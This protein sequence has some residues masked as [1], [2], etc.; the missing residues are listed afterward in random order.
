[1][2]NSMK[3]PKRKKKDKL[4]YNIIISLRET[5]GKDQGLFIEGMSVLTCELQSTQMSTDRQ[6]DKEDSPYTPW[7][8]AQSRTVHGQMDWTIHRQAD[9]QV[10]CCLYTPWNI[11]QSRTVH[12]QVD[13][14]TDKED[15]LIHHGIRFSQEQCSFFICRHCRELE[16]TVRGD[17]SDMETD[18][19]C[20]HLSV[21][22][23][24]L[25]AKWWGERDDQ[26]LGRGLG[27]GEG[28]VSG[29]HAA[30]G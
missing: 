2:E 28:R 23:E 3:I 24:E 10:R 25:I 29:H 26:S 11:T 27:R 14:R 21:G 30:E 9:K 7:N 18:T 20:L 5:L 1:M 19:A 12:G 13:R 15:I 22:S 4:L 16:K 17:R 6:T 8:T